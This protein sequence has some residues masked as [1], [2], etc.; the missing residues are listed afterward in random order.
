MECIVQYLDDLEDLF[1]ATALSWERLRRALTTL[2]SFA[3]AAGL[4]AIGI[5]LALVSPPAGIAYASLLLV[6]LLFGSVLTYRSPAE[7]AAA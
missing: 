5:Y 4:Q 3:L 1:Y 6:A 2:L 7:A